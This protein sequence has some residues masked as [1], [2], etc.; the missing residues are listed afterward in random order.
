[1]ST[2]AARS[3]EPDMADLRALG[4]ELIARDRW[5]R[6]RVQAFQ[7]ARLNELLAHAVERSPY[8][9]DV[10][11]PDAASL[12]LE[13]LPTLPKATL[14]D[15]FN[16]I[17]TDPRLRLEDLERH[18]KGRDPEAP[19]LDRY[20][21]FS[22]SGTSGLRALV[23]YS[24]EEFRFWV[25]VSL[26][27]FA[28]VGITPQTRLVAIGAPN[29][30]HITRQLFASFRSGRSGTPEL[31]V[32]TPLEEIV[33][34]LNDYQPEAVVGYTSIA[35]L[36]AQEQLEGRLRIAPRILGVSSEVLTD[37]ARRWIREAWD[38]QPTEV[39][40]STETLYIASSMPP[41]RDLYVYD[42]LAIVEVVDEENR[43]VPPGRPGYK[44]LVTNLVNRIQPLIRYELSD[45]VI[46]AAGADPGG[47]PFSRIAAVDGRSDDILRLPA[48]RGGEIAIH[49]YRL[50]EPFATLT[51]V[52]QYQIVQR[53]GGLEVRV[54]LDRSAVPETPE[55]V[56]TA[57]VRAVTEAGA[58]PPPLEVTPVEAIAREPGH[59]AKLKLVKR[60]E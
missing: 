23:V 5:S 60:L 49:P 35:A 41:H 25:A 12:P 55:R 58:V 50:R 27:L 34:A 10:L 46:F 20:L 19:Y 56:R 3:H 36:L 11:G 31:T 18:A 37:E 26:R 13:Q 9:R 32:L 59:G 15:Q 48:S 40:A 53:A 8:Y 44:L 22:T 42:D 24:E 17:V 39:Y 45:S 4:A 6:D 52:R 14:V 47:L 51:G 2:A 33:A 57:L 21:A 29:A 30:L 54:V 28:R 43:P 38:I 7:R 1:M 16:R